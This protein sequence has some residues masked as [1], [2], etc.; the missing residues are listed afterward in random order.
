MAYVTVSSPCI[1]CGKLFSYNPH[2]VPSIRLNADRQPDPNGTRE[3]ICE[4][5][6]ALVNP[7]RIASGL[8]PITYHPRAYEPMEEYELWD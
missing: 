7:K 1:A 6:V 5:C 2:L 3:P 4:S 8:E